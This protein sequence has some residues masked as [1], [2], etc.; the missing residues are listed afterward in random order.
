MPR[1]AVI[2]AGIVGASV[3][4]RLAEAGAQVWLIDA[5]QP[6]RGTTASS[7]AWINANRKTPRDYFAL[8]FAGLREH[9]RLRDEPGGAPWFHQD[10]N[11]EWAATPEGAT[12]LTARVARLQGWGYQADWRPAARVT[13]ELEPELPFNDPSLPVAFFPEEGWIDAPGLVTGFVERARTL[14]AE[15]RTGTPVTAIEMERDRVSAVRLDGGERLPV[16]AVV[17]AAGPSAGQVAAM[18]G[19]TLPMANRRGLLGRF[20]IPRPVLRRMFNGP[21]LNARPDGDGFLIV[22]E[23][24]MDVE[25]GD[26]SDITP[27]DPIARR[28]RDRAR[29]TLPV[30]ADAPMVRTRI[31]VRPVPADERT[32]AGTVTDRPGYYEAVTHSGVTLGPLLG[33]LLAGE[34]LT[35]EVDPLLAAFRPDRFANGQA[36]ERP[37]PVEARAAGPEGATR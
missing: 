33:R 15:V 6:G 1:I 19:R 35:G 34:I 8:N 11:F 7:F 4:L 28:L 24:G 16:D 36:L 21:H 18:V 29:A 31:R 3:A 37:S 20:A 23:E 32:C 13:A 2:G 27:D 5:A 10:G 9:E 30:L 25:L 22:Q 14:G 17:N 12:E 26:R